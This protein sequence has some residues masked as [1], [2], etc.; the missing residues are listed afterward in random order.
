MAFFV[1]SGSAFLPGATQAQTTITYDYDE[2]GRLTEVATGTAPVA[3]FDY[4]AA[5]NRIEH[6]VQGTS[7]P[8]APPPVCSPISGCTAN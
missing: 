3:T 7:V 2:L 5:D 1:L 8:A 6:D 4:D